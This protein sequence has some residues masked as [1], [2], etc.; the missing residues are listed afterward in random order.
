MRAS[1]AEILAKEVS[2]R[3]ARLG[4]RLALLPVDSD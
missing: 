2:Q 1:E 4:K 3:S